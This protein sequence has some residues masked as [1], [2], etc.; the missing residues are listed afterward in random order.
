MKIDTIIITQEQVNKILEIEESHFADFKSKRISPSKLTNTISALANA[1]G[2]EV[3]IGIEEIENKSK[4]S[5]D[6]F[7]TIEDA[8][9]FIQVFE[10]LFPLGDNFSYNFL[11]F[12]DSYVLKIEI[13]KNKDIIV[14]NDGE[15]Y[16]RRSAQNLKITSQEEI[17]RLKLDKG[18]YSFEDN[19]LDIPVEFVSDSLSIYEFMIEIIPTNEPLAWLKKQL[20]ILGDKPKVSAVLLFSDEPQAALPKQSAIKIYKYRTKAIEGTR[21]TLDFDPISIEGNLY[22]IIRESVTK[23]KEIIESSKILDEYGLQSVNY[24]AIALHEIITNAV[25]HR[26]YSIQ[27][28]IHIRIFDNRVEIESPGVL[29]GHVTI[30]N[31]LNEQ[32]A[33]NGTLVRL[34]NKFPD[35][36]NKDVGEG[37]NSAFDEIKNLR[38]KKPSIVEKENSVLVTILHEPLASAE[39]LI[40]EYLDTHDEITNAEGRELTGVSSADIM[41]QTFYKLRDKGLIKKSEDDGKQGRKSSWIK[42]K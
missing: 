27:A 33:R 11:H 35:A 2:G 26:D 40:I 39:Q 23:A 20:L 18:L 22:N 21:E 17:E 1:V 14:A 30:R 13:K 4:K 34:I 8:N 25:L 12:N 38:L 6:G 19:T 3:Y 10:K 42:I 5:W 28:D 29:P 24:P 37:L 7:S 16:K 36:P 31:I 32:F 41:K 9:G 15:I